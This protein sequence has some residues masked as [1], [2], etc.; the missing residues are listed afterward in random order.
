MKNVKQKEY[1]DSFKRASLD[2]EIKN[3]A[4]DDLEE[5]SNRLLILEK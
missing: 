5:Y 3:M 1:V 2:S 4:E